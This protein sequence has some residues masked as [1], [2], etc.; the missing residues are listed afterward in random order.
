[1]KAQEQ[2][3]ILNYL[4]TNFLEHGDFAR[5]VDVTPADLDA[6]IQSRIFPA[7][8][9][10][11]QS[12]GRS[13]S[14]VSDAPDD[15][16]YRFHLRGHSQW[17]QSLMRL[18][19]DTEARARGHF[20]TRYDQAKES[21][22]TSRLGAALTDL[23]PDVP[24][25][26]DADHADATWGH[27]L[28]GVYGVCTRDGQPETVFLKQAC[29]V[30]IDHMIAGGP[31]KMSVDEH[32]LL[33]EAVDFLDRVASDFAPN[34]VAQSSRQRCIIDVRTQFLNKRAA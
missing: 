4:Y 10:V 9:Y 14:F 34:E 32:R 21:F 29:V 25:R 30:F 27:F 31:G 18:G 33:H 11:Y 5:T 13:V 6:A 28:G 23:A 2:H 1:V 20:F 15:T 26:F 17:F 19:L 7:P 12:A 3:V 24:A 22:L 8:S 16:S